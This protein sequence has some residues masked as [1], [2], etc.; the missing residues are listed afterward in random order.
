VR[1]RIKEWQEFSE[2]RLGREEVLS[3]L[4]RL[5][6]ELPSA[7]DRHLHEPIRPPNLWAYRFSLG[8]APS[9]RHFSFAVERRDY[10]GELDVLDGTLTTE[11]GSEE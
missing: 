4:T 8:K 2:G 6:I 1:R 5:Y 11:T 7:P 10:V 9:R 3:V